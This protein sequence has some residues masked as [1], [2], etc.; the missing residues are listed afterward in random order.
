MTDFEDRLRRDL[1]IIWEDARQGPIRPL[2]VSPA[3]RRSRAVRWLAPV[4]AMAA[5]IGIITGVS[6][7]DRATGNRPP[8]TTAPAGI[9]KYYVTL[10]ESTSRNLTATVR[11][12]A[13]GAT[14]ASVPI[15]QHVPLDAAPVLN[16]PWISAAANDRVF[17]IGG[18]PFGLDILR[19]SPDGRVERLSRLPKKFS[20][21][22]GVL[23]PDGTELAQPAGPSLLGLAG[24]SCNKDGTTAPPTG[25]ETFWLSPKT[26]RCTTG[27][28]VVSLATGTA[29]TWRA[30]PPSMKVL[31]DAESGYLTEPINWAGDRH[32]V[33][34]S[35]GDQ[36]LV[37]NVAGPSGSLLA[38]SWRIASPAGQ[39]RWALWG[40][41][42]T[43]DGN[44]VIWGSFRLWPGDPSTLPG[45][46]PA[47]AAELTE[48][49]AVGRVVEFSART[50]RLLRVLHAAAARSP[51]PFILCVPESLGP[52]GLHA[53]IQ[54]TRFGRLDGSR[55][56]PLPRGFP[57]NRFVTWQEAAW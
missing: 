3:R 27:L 50:G 15:E 53:L 31:L 44:A 23:S 41:L 38:D 47:F 54:C 4:A 18:L 12:S 26:S 43:P 10:N 17:A 39:R 34:L 55:F 2:R 28:T 1:K 22:P 42:L 29:R 16:A 52:T 20:G 32:E 49:T 46:L 21:A 45:T 9:P 35:Y 57:A 40:P 8:S 11:D 48:R 25:G 36:Y 19:L 5:V 51:A 30:P 14:L 7:A 13:T 33:F 6:L 24:P 56:T 37:L